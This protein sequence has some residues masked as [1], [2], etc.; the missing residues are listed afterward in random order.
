MFKNGNLDTGRTLTV[1]GHIKSVEE[2]WIDEN[3]QAAQ[4]VRPRMH[5]KQVQLL[6]GGL[7]PAPKKENAPSTVKQLVKLN[8]RQPKV[9]ETPAVTPRSASLTTV[10]L[11]CPWLLNCSWGLFFFFRSHRASR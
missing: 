1:T 2:I 4:L 9:D 3:G 5:L 11:N 10:T 7:G 6:D 8:D